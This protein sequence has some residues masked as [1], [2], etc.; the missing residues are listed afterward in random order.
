MK[1]NSACLHALAATLTSA[2]ELSH[3]KGVPWTLTHT[4]PS[5][6]PPR[7]ALVGQLLGDP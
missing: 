4:M 5:F 7:T 2:S 6:L 1:T 3:F